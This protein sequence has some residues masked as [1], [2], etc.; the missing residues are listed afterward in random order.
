[1]PNYAAP[2]EDLRF[3]LNELVDL[4]E[5]RTMPG[6]EEATPDVVDAIL[7]EA[8]RLASEVLAP[9]NRYGDVQAPAVKDGVVTTS[10][11]WRA[12]YQR[13]AEGG[14][15]ALIFDPE[16]GGQGLPR[17]LAVAVQEMWDASNMSFGL[18][19]LLTCS[20]AEAISLQGS[21]EQK[22]IYLTKLVSGE[23]RSEE[24]TSELQSQ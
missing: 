9:L 3:V 18:C 19:P 21:E 4:G 24:H 20:A 6:Y 16:Y 8:G 2:V 7:N 15:T 14:W 1:M 23:W 10:P 13:F 11:E 5:I 17:V 12:A 22:R